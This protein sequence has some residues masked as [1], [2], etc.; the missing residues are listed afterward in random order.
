MLAP[1]LAGVVFIH[2]FRAEGN[3]HLHAGSSGCL[4]TRSHQQLSVLSTGMMLTLCPPGHPTASLLRASPGSLGTGL[5]EVAIFW[6]LSCVNEPWKTV[7]YIPSSLT[8]AGSAVKGLCTALQLPQ[9]PRIQRF[10][11]DLST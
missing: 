2:S 10:L 8:G 7:L 5:G 11:K 3:E 1:C 9:H 4:C 6:L